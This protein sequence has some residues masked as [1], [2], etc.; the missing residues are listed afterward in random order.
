MRGGKE[1]SFRSYFLTMEIA[2][3]LLTGL[4]LVI[5]ARFSLSQM[6]RLYFESRVTDAKHFHVYRENALVLSDED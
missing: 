1:K 2:H 4:L 3:F 5:A 6:D